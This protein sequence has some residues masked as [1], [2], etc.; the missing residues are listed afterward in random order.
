MSVFV[1]VCVWEGGETRQNDLSPPLSFPP[2]FAR[3]NNVGS[4]NK[5]DGNQGDGNR[6]SLNIGNKNVGSYNR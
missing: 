6:G 4:F 3:S 5:G 2:P 1:C